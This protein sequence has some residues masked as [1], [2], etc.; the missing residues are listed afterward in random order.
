MDMDPELR[1]HELG[2]GTALSRWSLSCSGVRFSLQA[3]QELD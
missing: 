1:L 3:R 2:Y